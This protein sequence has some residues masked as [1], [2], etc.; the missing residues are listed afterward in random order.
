LD[1]LFTPSN[2]GT[3]F[4]LTLE[5]GGKVLGKIESPRGAAESE[6]SVARQL[7]LAYLADKDEI[8]KPVEYTS[9]L[10]SAPLP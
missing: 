7:L 6:F 1:L 10:L 3:G 4:D 5:E 9:P 8:S 2:S